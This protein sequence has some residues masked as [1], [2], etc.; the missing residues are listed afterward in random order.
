MVAIKKSGNIDYRCIWYAFIIFNFFLIF[1]NENYDYNI[2]ILAQVRSKEK[3]KEILGDYSERK[4]ISIITDDICKIFQTSETADYIIH[5][6]SMASP[7]YYDSVPIDVALPNAIGTYYLLTY[8]CEHKCKGFLYFS[9]GDIYGKMPSG[10]DI[11][12]DMSGCVDPLDPHSC[13]GESKR[14]GETWCMAFAKQKNVPTKIVRVG[15]TYG[16]TM[17]INHD[18]RVFASFM[19]NIFYGEDIVMYSDGR[20]KRPFC[21]IADA[22]AAFLTVLLYGKNGNAYNVCNTQEFLSMNELAQMLIKLRPEKKLKIIYKQRSSTEP[23][24]E[25]KDNKENKPVEDK[26]KQL[27]WETHFSAKQ[28]FSNTLLYLEYVNLEK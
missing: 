5:A 3:I 1:L 15:H 11:Y 19:K 21:Y 8:A 13:Y 22:T 2:K 24:L 17:D 23:Y 20:A 16:P 27:G 6:A 10:T 12:E 18:P 4:Y 25:N 26:L 28:G 7:R 14:M 9:S